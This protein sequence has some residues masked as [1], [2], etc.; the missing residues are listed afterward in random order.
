MGA[1]KKIV[2]DV[3]D[4]K[5]E[6]Y[7]PKSLLPA[8]WLVTH[9]LFS[10]LRLEGRARLSSKILRD[11]LGAE[12]KK[13]MDQLQP[14]LIKLERDYSKG[15]HCREFKFVPP[16]RTFCCKTIIDPDLVARYERNKTNRKT[17]IHRWLDDILGDS[18]LGFDDRSATTEIDRL[19]ESEFNGLHK[20]CSF[21]D[22][23]T[24]L[25]YSL[26]KA[27]RLKIHYANQR[28]ELSTVDEFGFRYHHP[29]TSL[30]KSFRR[31]IRWNGQGLVNVDIRNS[32]PLFLCLAY[33]EAKGPTTPDMLRYK[34]LCEDGQ[35]YE[36]LN[37][38][39]IPR[40]EF[41]EKF[42]Q[43]ILF[44]TVNT[45]QGGQFA[46]EFQTNF[47]TVFGYILS[48]KTPAPSR[49]LRGEDKE[50]PHRLA[51]KVLQ[52]AESGF[53]FDR[54]IP[55]LKERG[56]KPVIPIHDSILTTPEN[57]PTVQTVIEQEF[58]KV[59]FKCGVRVDPT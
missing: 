54:V 20:D 22:Y 13:I 24:I 47:P 58:A 52:R 43:E 29:F 4:I 2:V 25:S 8:T 19:T 26:H 45:M 50:R 10:L 12:S 42:F 33:T 6:D 7:V 1:L 17:K 16:F 53:M 40:E 3:P 9:Q 48:L 5:Y 55:E 41:K 51:S 34:S 23:K 28:L 49:Q 44:A 15:L 35:L 32:Q 59:G 46:N 30:P 57:G 31:F 38:H 21:D 56:V 11:L 36:S 39:N 18:A 14:D 37:Q 27:T